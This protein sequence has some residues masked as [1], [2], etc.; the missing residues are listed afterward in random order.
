MDAIL[1]T[2]HKDIEPFVSSD[3]ILKLQESEKRAEQESV[4]AEEQATQ[5]QAQSGHSEPGGGV[6]PP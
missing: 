5:V 3:A 4:L 6:E 2:L 1:M